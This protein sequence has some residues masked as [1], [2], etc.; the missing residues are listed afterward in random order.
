M[1]DSAIYVKDGSHKNEYR[2]T[3][4]QGKI[5]YKHGD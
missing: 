1:I 5:G 3:I 4:S 2:Y